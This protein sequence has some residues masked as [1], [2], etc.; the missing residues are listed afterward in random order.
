MGHQHTFESIA[1]GDTHTMTHTF[2]AEA[3]RAFADI[4]GDD[5][6][7]HVDEAYAKETRF[8]TCIV[9][10]VYLMGL[11]SKQLGHD[12]PGPGCIAVQ[13]TTKFARPVPVGAEVSFTVKVVEKIEGRRQIRARISAQCNGKMALG[14]EVI[15]V[16]PGG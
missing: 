8:G 15:F 3:V 14:G 10:G 13:I 5:N 9:H 4:T 11:V 2:A 16:P 6:P 7:I 1:I 12:Y